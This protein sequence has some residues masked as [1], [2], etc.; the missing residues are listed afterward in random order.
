M[1]LGLADSLRS[2]V[3]LKEVLQA[4]LRCPANQQDQVQQM[5]LDSFAQTARQVS[6][7]VAASPSKLS[8]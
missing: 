1:V 2:D 6:Q 4:A 5:A 8:G 3:S 7:Q